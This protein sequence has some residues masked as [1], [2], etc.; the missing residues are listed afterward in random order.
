MS[1]FA[2]G[3]VVSA[4]SS[5]TSA[6]VAQTATARS[7]CSELS[8]KVASS[9]LGVTVQ[10]HECRD[11]AGDQSTG[12]YI[13]VGTFPGTLIVNT[14]WNPKLLVNFMFAHSGRAQ[15]VEVGGKSIPPPVYEM[16]H[17]AGVP[18]YWRDEQAMSPG[19][20]VIPAR[21][22]FQVIEATRNG[23]VVMITSQSFSRP[24]VQSVLAAMLTRL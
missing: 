16:V 11:L 19:N 3:S 14:S 5:S 18:A 10:A 21:S 7:T 1:A 2:L 13:P 12:L 20:S 22:A 6:P 17:V 23:Y 4:C 24:Q 9:A 15:I 8:D